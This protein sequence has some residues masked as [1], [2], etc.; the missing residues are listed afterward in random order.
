MK[1]VLRFAAET[2]R[3]QS[4]VHMT[5][6]QAHAGILHIQRFNRGRAELL[7]QL[8]RGLILALPTDYTGIT[9]T[10]RIDNLMNSYI[11][12]ARFD[13]ISRMVYD[14][15]KAEAEFRKLPVE[16]LVACSIFAGMDEI[17]EILRFRC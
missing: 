6:Q 5:V 17:W 13:E 2:F 1:F 3:G 15:L 8:A 12:G 14:N 4:L 10:N 9:C 7:V 16:S 11:Y